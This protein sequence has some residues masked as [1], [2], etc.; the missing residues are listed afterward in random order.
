MM[1]KILNR[2]FGWDYVAF[3]FGGS[4]FIERVKI[5]PNG[6]YHIW[7]FRSLR[8]LNKSTMTAL[9]FTWEEY[10]EMTNGRD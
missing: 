8:V 9:T 4:D 7:A 10:E 3:R 1:Y 2:L 5:T 6:I